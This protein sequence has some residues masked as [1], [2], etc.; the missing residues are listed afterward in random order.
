M[1]A[2][3]TPIVLSVADW[4][5]DQIRYMQPKVNDRGG[6]SIN[7]VSTQ[8]NRSLHIS[9]PLMMTW[10]ISDFVDEKTGESDGK[11][12]MSLN[13][14][15][16]D[17]STPAAEEFLAKLKDFD[18]QIIDDA[19]KNSEAWF[20][21]ELSREIIQHAYSGSVKYSNIKG[22]KKP[23]LTKPP[24]IRCKV[25][26]YNGKWGVEIYDTKS[27]RI[28][29]CENENMTPM[30]FVAK[31]SN[32]A[33]VLQCGGLWSVAGKWGIIWKLNQCVV[34]PPEVVSVF[35]RCHVQLSGDDIQMMDTAP[36]AKA[37]DEEESVAPAKPA[38]MSTEV[39]DSDEDEIPSPAPS[40]VP[41]V[42]QEPVT[43]AKDSA[44]PPK[45]KTV[46]KKKVAA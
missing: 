35:G 17:Y 28:F 31:R 41:E 24:S 36:L 14:P 38:P 1:A 32:L 16:A 19:V 12:S 46:V 13:F 6:K 27:N 37:A 34:K 8:T 26:C 10:G 44:E 33:A 30:D 15:N 9:T 22:T 5:T 3:S 25:P 45:K 23:D 42:K 7:I 40:A 39:E 18:K 11:F 20:G 43:E 2:K 29:P 21:E 4:K